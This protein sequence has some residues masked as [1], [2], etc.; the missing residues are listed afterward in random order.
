M[1]RAEGGCKCDSNALALYSLEKYQFLSCVED[2][3]N[4]G[5]LRVS[6]CFGSVI[7]SIYLT[8]ANAYSGPGLWFA[9]TLQPPRE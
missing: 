6:Y 1:H 3:G 7:T 2:L 8:E 4:V 5:T 9:G